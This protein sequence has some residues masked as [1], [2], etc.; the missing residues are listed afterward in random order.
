MS[1]QTNKL[2]VVTGASAGI[3]KAFAFEL[4]NHG[5]DVH[6]VARR[7]ANLL[8]ICERLNS[9]R[10]NSA[11]FSALDLLDPDD[12]KELELYLSSNDVLLLV[13]N[14]GR[15]SYGYFEQLSRGQEND[16]VT[17]N[18]DVPLR[19]AHA[20]IPTLFPYTTLFI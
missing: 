14:V 17:L 20:V 16:M 11:T 8:D 9:R 4:H 3:G 12:C 10:V 5:Y 18:V 6:L 1:Q 15:G 19:L 13:N 7:E 2:A